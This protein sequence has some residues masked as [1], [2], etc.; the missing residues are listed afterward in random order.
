MLGTRVSKIFRFASLTFVPLLM[1]CTSAEEPTEDVGSTQSELSL[2]PMR[3]ERLT[4]PVALA[5]GQPASYQVVGWL[6]GRG[7]IQHD[8]I[9][10][11]VHGAT[12]SHTYWDFPYERDRYSYASAVTTAGFA[13]LAI[14]RIGIG[15]S[16][17]P[18][19]ID[20]TIAANAHVVHQVVQ[21]LRSGALRVPG[22]GRI[23]GERVM[24]VGHSL[25]SIV[26]IRE[27]ATYHDVDGVILTGYL[28]NS[29]PAIPE[30]TANFVPV[31]LDPV[32]AGRN[33]PAGYITTRAGTRGADYFYYAPTTD[34]NLVT[35]DEATKETSTVGE[36]LD[37]AASAAMSPQID[38]PVLS[39]VGNL[40]RLFC[41]NPSCTA[42]GTLDREYQFFSPAAQLQIVSIPIASHNI[43]LHKQAP[44]WYAL[45]ATWSTLHVGVDTRFPAPLGH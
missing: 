33:L 20:V 41:D 45:A 34:P 32:L 6:C 25:G 12:Y 23:R 19:A 5:E 17:H 37:Y 42:A 4:F 36:T 39:V 26:S 29:G 13:T 35:V 22:F 7:S 1:A 9:Q 3:C 24:L 38:V 16:D 8:T 10:V 21:T 18:P 15:E 44:L 2:A 43:N 11:L 31:Q 27:A 28:H 40:D 30:I 14:D